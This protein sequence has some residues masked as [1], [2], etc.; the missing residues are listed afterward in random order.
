MITP[1]IIY[2]CLLDGYMFIYIYTYIIPYINELSLSLENHGGFSHLRTICVP[3]QF[4]TEVA[5]IAPED[6]IVIPL[7]LLRHPRLEVVRSE[8]TRLG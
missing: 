3:Q 2:A 1:H 5:T 8:K 4:V 7:P 6:V